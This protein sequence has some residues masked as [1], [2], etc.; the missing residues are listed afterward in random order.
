L[1][2]NEKDLE[3]ATI[4]DLGI[5]RS[6]ACESFFCVSRQDIFYLS[7]FCVRRFLNASGETLFWSDSLSVC[8]LENFFKEMKNDGKY[9]CGGAGSKTG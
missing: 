3:I 7:F 4:T 6:Q 8:R 5:L 9:I 2:C 1:F